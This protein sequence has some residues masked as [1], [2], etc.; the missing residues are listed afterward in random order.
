MWVLE[1]FKQ[2]L[3]LLTSGY[4]ANL[5]HLPGHEFDIYEV[6]SKNDVMMHILDMLT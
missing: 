2:N 1:K 5:A 3:Q 6:K 4:E